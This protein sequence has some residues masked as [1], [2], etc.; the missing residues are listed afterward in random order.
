[1]RAKRTR[2]SGQKRNATGTASRVFGWPQGNRS[3]GK[4]ASPSKREAG[5]ERQALET[6]H[7]KGGREGERERG[8]F[9]RSYEKREKG[10]ERKTTLKGNLIATKF[11]D[12][13]E[14]TEGRGKGG[15]KS[16]SSR[17]EG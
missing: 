11:N 8:T 3:W 10:L 13:T 16:S 7:L 12:L 1:L 6:K 2:K 15:K 17:L 4:N 9:C 5:K 14:S